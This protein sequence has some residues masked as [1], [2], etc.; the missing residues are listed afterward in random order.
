MAWYAL[1]VKNKSV[2][3]GAVVWAWQ[4]HTVNQLHQ[5]FYSTSKLCWLLISLC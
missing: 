5:L 2:N 1:V 3:S 4:L